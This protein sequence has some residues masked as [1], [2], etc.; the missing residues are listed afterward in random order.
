MTF[1]QNTKE[2]S[3]IIFF[4][5]DCEF[6]V[7]MITVQIVYKMNSGVVT[8]NKI[9]VSSTYLNQREGAARVYFASN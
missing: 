3:F 8:A 7:I 5:F 4:K 2:W 6:D 9:K 1:D